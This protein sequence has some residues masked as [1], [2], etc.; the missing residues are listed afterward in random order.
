MKNPKITIKSAQRINIIPLNMLAFSIAFAY[1][2]VA[3]TQTSSESESLEE[4]QVWGTEVK[5]SS[6]A[7]EGE[8]MA[9]KQA[10]HVSDLLRTIPGVDVGGAHSLNQ[11]ITIRSM[12]DKDLQISID[13]ANQNSYMY[14]HMGNLQIH[15]DILQSVDIDIGTNS[16]LN[17]GLG[18]AVKFKTKSADQLLKDGAKSGGRLQASYGDNS[19]SRLALTGFAKLTDTVDVL[20][21]YN[22]VNRKN[23]EIGGGQIKDYSGNVI[24][25]TDGTVRGLEGDL[26]DGLIKLGWDLT[27][28]QRLEVGFEAYKDKGDYSYRP[29]MG[30]ATDLAITN[31]LEIP[32]LWPT[33]F[34]R[35]T[36]TINHELDWG[37]HSYLRTSVFSN[38]SELS[39]DESGWAANEGFAAYA[40]Q[41]TGEA[42]N[43]G[44]S[45]L[46][47]TELEK[48]TLTYG[49][50]LNQ[51]DTDYQ[52]S[53][54]AGSTD[55]SGESADT[56]AIYIQDR[57][58]VGDSLA[59]VPGLRFN[60]SDVDAT[61]VSKTYNKITGA[62]AAEY[63]VTN[64]LLLKASATQL[65]KA[66]EIGEV[67]TGGGLRDTENTG[68]KAETGLN[69]E[70]ALAFEDRVFGADRFAAGITVFQ[71]ALDDYIYDYAPTEDGNWKDNV[72]D[73]SIDGY[74]LYVGYDKGPLKALLSYSAAESELNAGAQ[75]V[76]LDGARLDRQQ[77]DTISLNIDYDMS[78][79]NLTLH[80]D[81]LLV[82]G[83]KAAL[84][85]DGASQ[86][87]A[88]DGFAVHNISARWSPQSIKGLGLTVGVD[89]LF[90]EYYASQSSRTGLSFHPRFGELFL[91]DYEPGRNI[92]LTASYDF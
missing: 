18:G 6:V 76:D 26:G 16:V 22:L 40:G 85:L 25:G 57:I 64:N 24:D 14:H 29:D 15:A 23:Y 48:H 44:I 70:L 80:W 46:G 34:T 84:D 78:S 86:D 2:G 90:D 35:N 62:L 12:D 58:A 82:K 11:R 7:L 28:S 52:A 49:A 65:F 75:Y 61:V 39:R 13:G 55:K 88:K 69:S 72:G 8:T 10:D 66:P 71:T 73:M 36:L 27:E 56:M 30:L 42:K 50:E 77:G 9:I 91:Q 68:I 53:Y 5:A 63:R 38:I 81:T 89:N 74:E 60:Q 67:F 31:S 41:V 4:V 3:F 59:L 54:D 83:V 87:N 47:E 17:G 21:Y 19:G 79:K 43:T 45:T 51:Y 20:G 33:E 32:L 37:G 1:S 92:K